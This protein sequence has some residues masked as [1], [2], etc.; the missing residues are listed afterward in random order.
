MT[1]AG[2]GLNVSGIKSA[3]FLVLIGLCA[4]CRTAPAPD[5]AAVR[6]GRADLAGRVREDF[7]LCWKA[8]E[9]YAWGHDELKPVSRTPRD[10]YGEPLLMTPVDAL[11]TMIL[12]GLDSEA[13]KAR[14][15]IDR[16]LSFDRDVTV[17][18]F[19]VTIR[20]LGG[21]LSGCELTGD[22]RLLRLASDLG[23]RLLPA[24]DSPT[25]MPYMYVN[26]KTG[27]ASGAKSNPAEIGTL[28][29]EF[30]TLSE[31]TGNPVFFEKAK[32]AL[33]ALF[34]RRSK[35]GLVGEEIDVE[36]GGWLGRTSHVSGGID[37][38]YEYLLKASILFGDEDCARMWRDSIDAVNRY[39]PERS[40]GGYW[41]G[42]ADMETGLRVSSRYG[43]LDAFLPAVLSLGGDLDRA[44]RLQ[45]S[46]YRMW[47]LHGVEPESLDYRTMTVV[48]PGYPLR[49]EI[50]ESAYY[51]YRYTGDPRYL[52]MGKTILGDLEKYC[53]T[54]DGF[55][56]LTSV[57][58]KEKGD[59]MPSF[60]LAETLKYLYLL[61]SPDDRA[62]FEHVIFNTEAHPLRRTRASRPA[63]RAG[64]IRTSPCPRPPAPSPRGK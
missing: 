40:G 50:V 12:M 63:S 49:P 34:D 29:L 13:A 5:S 15:L 4:C 57:L 8:Y 39:L 31:R 60:F 54:E 41:Y 33:V 43:A 62:D 56:V 2:R 35:I 64:R 16:E 17:K 55:T 30:G 27:K 38:Y 53:R 22:E 10:W 14:E 47:R 1:R 36:T 48:E 24:F 7:L 37:S 23:T 61:F 19:E 52:E 18:N 44:I 21:L 32:A 59:L 9:K 20:L 46:G 6:T 28:L 26:L 11:D 25:R 51:L 58:T 45:D 42:Q 3:F